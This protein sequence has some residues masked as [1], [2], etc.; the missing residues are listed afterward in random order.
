MLQ[1]NFPALC[2]V[3]SADLWYLICCKVKSVETQ[4]SKL[5]E[6]FRPHVQSRLF[7]VELKHFLPAFFLEMAW[8]WTNNEMVLQNILNEIINN[9]S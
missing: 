7:N 6:L 3:L 5:Y 1:D 4:A 8:A 2:T 9:Q